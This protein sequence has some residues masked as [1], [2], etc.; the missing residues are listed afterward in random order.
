MSIMPEGVKVYFGESLKKKL[1][2]EGKI[3]GI[4]EN[5]GYNF[6]QLPN[7]EYYEDLKDSFSDEMKK[8]MIKFVD[9][10]S[11]K[12]VSLRPD[13]TS[14]VA[15]LM[16]L[17]KDD[18]THPERLCYIGDTFRYDKIKSGI[19]RQKSQAGLELIGGNA[20]K[21]DIEVLV[22]AIELLKS[23][24]SKEA[25]IEL[26]DTRI[27]NELADKS[28]LDKAKRSELKDL[29]SKKD[30]PGLDSFVE[31]NSCDEVLKKLPLMIGK[32]EVL[33]E[34]K[35]EGTDYLAKIIETLDKLGYE[36]NY[37]IDL[38]VVKDMEYYTGIV[39]NGFINEAVDFVISG[40]RYDKLIG[41]NATGFVVNVDSLVENLE[42]EIKKERK[43]YL[44]YG[45]DYT[46]MIKVKNTLIAQ[47]ER[48]ESIIDEK[49]VEELKAYAIKAGYAYLKDA[50]SE[51]KISVAG[52]E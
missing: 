44:V 20:F 49:T 31:E 36:D 7:Y 6:I 42:I 41:I 14:L 28:G 30:V 27:F 46:K 9:R 8:R 4:F 13:M 34:I 35:N 50:D 23:L 21:A 47:G 19:Y 39:F 37:V 22:M 33:S 29:I 40:G 32:K 45:K 43:G 2:I 11:G 18:I 3:K 38:S 16:K 25:K 52:D 15:K 48:V 12:V 5:N 24:G 51:E 26:G 1:A 17:K 10:D